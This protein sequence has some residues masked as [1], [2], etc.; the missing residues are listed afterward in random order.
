MSSTDS[1]IL[2]RSLI[3]EDKQMQL[4]SI[5]REANLVRT[6]SLQS[7]PTPATPGI[8]TSDL[9]KVSANIEGERIEQMKQNA[10]AN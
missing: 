5:R 3:N 9:F 8:T 10:K 1:E 4:E 2:D 6:G 7:K